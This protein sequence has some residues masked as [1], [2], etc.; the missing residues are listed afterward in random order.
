MRLLPDFVGREDGLTFVFDGIRLTVLLLVTPYLPDEGLAEGL[1]RLV[2]NDASTVEEFWPVIEGKVLALG[3]NDG[4]GDEADALERPLVLVFKVV[5]YDGQGSV[6][7]EVGSCCDDKSR[8]T[9]C[10]S[11]ERVLRGEGSVD[12]EDSKVSMR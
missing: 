8:E 7:F 11:D 9:C 6:A 1:V 4:E 12:D 2:D 5:A 3:G 10:E